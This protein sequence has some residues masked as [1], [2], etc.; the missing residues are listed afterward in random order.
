[1]SPYF[2]PIMWPAYQ[3]LYKTIIVFQS[4][5][6]LFLIALLYTHNYQDYACL[7]SRN[8]CWKRRED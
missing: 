7:H 6:T 8:F 2:V 4:L 1:M 5:A 3:Y